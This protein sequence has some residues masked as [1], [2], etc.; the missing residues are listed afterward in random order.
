MTKEIDDL[1]APL[2]RAH[3]QDNRITFQSFVGR[4]RADPSH[5][6]HATAVAYN[7]AV[8][9]MQNRRVKS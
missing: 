3:E 6:L 9:E 8:Y 7:R 4:L 1:E 2:R 5:L